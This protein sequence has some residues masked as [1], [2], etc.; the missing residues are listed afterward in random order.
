MYISIDPYIKSVPLTYI[1]QAMQPSTCKYHENN[2]SKHT[3]MC[4]MPYLIN[5]AQYVQV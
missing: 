4:M 3:F 5:E 2:D 1:I